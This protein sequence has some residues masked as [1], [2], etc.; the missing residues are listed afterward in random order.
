MGAFIGLKVFSNL[1]EQ[2]SS[3]ITH[4]VHFEELILIAGPF[5]PVIKTSPYCWL[6]LHKHREE[7]NTI[8]NYM[9]SSVQKSANIN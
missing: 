3:Q 5:L 8:G 2:R 4:P 6:P 9:C 1:R 7:L